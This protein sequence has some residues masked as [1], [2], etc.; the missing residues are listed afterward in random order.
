MIYVPVAA[1][2]LVGIAAAAA[3]AAAGRSAAAVA[4]GIPEDKG[5]G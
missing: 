4:C 1:E 2:Q 3:P 5:E